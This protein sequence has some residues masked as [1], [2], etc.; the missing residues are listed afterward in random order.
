MLVWDGGWGRTLIMN[1]RGSRR[2]EVEKDEDSEDNWDE[3]EDG[4]R[5]V[6]LEMIV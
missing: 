3:Y 4:S 2:E 1:R 6:V 5:K